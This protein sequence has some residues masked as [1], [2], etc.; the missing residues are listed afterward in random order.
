VT[1]RFGQSTQAHESP[2][3]SYQ[4][5]GIAGTSLAASRSWLT[6]GRVFQCR[7][8]GTTHAFTGQLQQAC[9]KT[10][11]RSKCS[12]SPIWTGIQQRVTTPAQ[13]DHCAVHFPTAPAPLGPRWTPPP[14][15]RQPSTTVRQVSPAISSIRR[16]DNHWRAAPPR[17]RARV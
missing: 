1:G 4:C 6:K 11:F 3:L 7:Q 16:T 8:F 15:A 14:L 5:K 17:L 10:C 2:Q 13:S 12:S 9:L